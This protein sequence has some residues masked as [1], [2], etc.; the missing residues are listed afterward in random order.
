[1]SLKKLNEPF[2]WALAHAFGALIG[3][4]KGVNPPYLTS[5]FP[6]ITLPLILA[7]IATYFGVLIG[8]AF[9]NLRKQNV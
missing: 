7:M 1:M 9:A 4:N 2:C 8:K 3:R 5:P 6:L